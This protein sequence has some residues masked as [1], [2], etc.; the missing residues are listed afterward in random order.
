V[1]T[2]SQADKI[3]RVLTLQ[4]TAQLAGAIQKLILNINLTF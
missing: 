2:I 3:S 1:S 4:A